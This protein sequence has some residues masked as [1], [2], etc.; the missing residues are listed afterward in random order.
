MPLYLDKGESLKLNISISG[1]V[2]ADLIRAYFIKEKAVVDKYSSTTEAG[3]GDIHA[4]TYDAVTDTTAV[5]VHVEASATA[6]YPSGVLS[7]GVMTAKAEAGFDESFRRIATSE[8]Q[9]KVNETI[10]VAD[11]D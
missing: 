10:D 9:I 5:E 7:V 8:T 2:S 11:I 4:V 6:L 3:F 1:D